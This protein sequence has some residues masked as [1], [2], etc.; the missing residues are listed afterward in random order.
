MENGF[1]NGDSIG[2]NGESKKKKKKKNKK[3]TEE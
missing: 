1:G 3:D 2:E